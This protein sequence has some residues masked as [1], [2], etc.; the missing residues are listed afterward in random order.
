MVFCNLVCMD[1]TSSSK[2]GVPRG[3]PHLLSWRVIN[4]AVLSGGG[5]KIPLH[6]P[7]TIQSSNLFGKG[8]E[9]QSFW[10][11]TTASH[12][13]SHLPT[14]VPYIF[15]S[16]SSVL[17]PSCLP[18]IVC[19]SLSLPLLSSCFVLLFL[20]SSV[21]CSPYFLFLYFICWFLFSISVYSCPLHS[22]VETRSGS[23][24]SYPIFINR[25]ISSAANPFSTTCLISVY[26]HPSQT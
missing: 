10:P 16:S 25:L 18:L 2:A 23:L 12:Y 15:L 24:Q 17:L 3:T 5:G 8:L 22:V 13:H 11:C 14:F 6:S 4:R 26:P 20:T 7:S 21:F 1:D 9:K 19:L